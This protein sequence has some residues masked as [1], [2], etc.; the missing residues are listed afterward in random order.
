MFR[1]STCQVLP[2]ILL[3]S[4]SSRLGDLS[5][6]VYTQQ[7]VRAP[8]GK[9][10]TYLAGLTGLSV[11]IAKADSCQELPAFLT[12]ALPSTSGGHFVVRSVCH[13]PLS[14]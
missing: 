7:E 4:H 13:T 1:A 9:V 11:S 5:I 12:C 6:P 2:L 14:L 10:R 8:K 3:R